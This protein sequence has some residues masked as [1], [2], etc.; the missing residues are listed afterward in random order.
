MKKNGKKVVSILLMVCLLLMMTAC[1]SKESKDEAGDAGSETTS[2]NSDLSK[3]EEAAAAAKEINPKEFSGPT[4]KAGKPAEGIKIAAI[5]SD[6]SL[7]GCVAPCDGIK[8]AAEA[9]GWECQYFDGEGN[10]ATQNEMILNAISWG[11]DIIACIA[12]D[13][14]GIQQSLQAAK[15]AG[16]ICI[17]GSAGIDS[18][19]DLPEGYD[20]D[21]M[22]NFEFDVSPDLYALTYAMGEWV[23]NDAKNAGEVAVFCDNQFPSNVVAMNG[24]IDAI[25]SSDMVCGEPQ[26]FNG[27]QV[28]D[29]LNRQMISYLTAHPECTHVWAPYDPAAASMVEGL[30]Q[31]GM[32]DIRLVASLGISQ[33]MQFVANNDVQVADVAYDNNYMGWAMVDQV[34]RL[35]NEKELF[36]PHGEN[37][38]YIVFDSTNIPEEEI[39]ANWNANDLW[40]YED[41]FVSLWTE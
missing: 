31:A 36:E 35:M 38:P 5:A 8:G 13:P 9:I 17:S 29:T 19:N 3:W 7:G 28:G 30:K 16:I 25:E 24:F 37:I 40:N 12:I 1:G 2:E 39:N 34:I 23:I 20:Y 41:T 33:N 22:L 27:S 11:A 32:T 10:S 14:S 26:Y 21:G 15:D 6:G 18:P 4:E